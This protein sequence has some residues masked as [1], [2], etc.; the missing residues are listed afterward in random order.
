MATADNAKDRERRAG[1]RPRHLERNELGRR[2]ERLAARR[3][4]H[5]DEIA[6][7]SGVSLETIYRISTGRISDPRVSTLSALAEALGVP[8]SKLIAPR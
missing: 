6:E 7:A 5:L 3:H 4:K 2:I 1:G 8:V